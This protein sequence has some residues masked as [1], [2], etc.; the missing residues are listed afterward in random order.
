MIK[1]NLLRVCIILGIILF[2]G[3]GSNGKVIKECQ[4]ELK[5]SIRI[6]RMDSL[7][8]ER[9]QHSVLWQEIQ[10]QEVMLS[11]PDSLERQYPKHIISEI[12]T[13]KIT[14]DE[15]EKIKQEVTET[16]EKNRV[17]SIYEKDTP[18]KSKKIFI[19]ITMI[20]MI[21]CLGLFFRVKK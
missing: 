4:M 16:T 9:V 21:I 15:N 19:L 14:E 2:C 20:Y 1:W 18:V 3:C 8:A 6:I 11:S 7:W 10:R 12:I 17:T 13:T 5:D